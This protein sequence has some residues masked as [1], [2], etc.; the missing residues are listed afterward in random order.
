MIIAGIISTFAFMHSR[1]TLR[2]N[3]NLG[4][5]VGSREAPRRVGH[6]HAVPTPPAD[7][8]A[9]LRISLRDPNDTPRRAWRKRGATRFGRSHLVPAGADVT[10]HRGCCWPECGGAWL[11]LSSYPAVGLRRQPDFRSAREIDRG[12]RQDPLVCRGSARSTG[13]R[14]GCITTRVI[15]SVGFTFMHGMAVT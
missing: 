15:I 5:V 10:R 1:E 13:S 4:W 3:R 6:G 9:A 8:N 14:S 2:H 7:Y 12:A 11:A